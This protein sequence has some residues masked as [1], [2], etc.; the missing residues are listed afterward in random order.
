VRSIVVCVIAALGAATAFAETPNTLLDPAVALDGEHGGAVALWGGRV[1]AHAADV[2]DDCLEVGALP[3]RPSDGRP[4]RRDRTREGQHFIACGP[5]EFA[6]ADH[7]VRS[8]L[9]VSGTVRGVERRFVRRGCS[10]LIDDA[11][12][13]DTGSAREPAPRGC[14]VML[15]IVDVDDSRSWRED[16]TP[17]SMPQ[18]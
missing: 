11:G 6:S 5:G 18:L 12:H 3:L 1:F 8:Y 15:P 17:G 7:P 9:T 13:W 16:P 14:T 10:Y 2:G 4:V